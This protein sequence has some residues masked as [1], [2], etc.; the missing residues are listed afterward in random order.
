[1]AI[2]VPSERKESR[3][4]IL[5][6]FSEGPLE[7]RHSL[8][9]WAPPLEMEPALEVV[10]PGIF[11]EQKSARLGVAMSVY[12]AALIRNDLARGL[13]APS[14]WEFLP[15]A[16]SPFPLKAS[17]RRPL[18]PVAWWSRS[19]I[20]IDGFPSAHTR[21]SERDIEQGLCPW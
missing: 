10:I 4:E 17:R 6:Y 15:R 14:H 18:A 9:W 19:P 3:S 20:W 16:K 7:E 11:I 12:V 5:D 21:R 8:P 2:W 1:M 13:D